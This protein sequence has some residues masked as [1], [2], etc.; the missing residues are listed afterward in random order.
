MSAMDPFPAAPRDHQGALAD[1]LTEK[2]IEILRLLT[3][4]HTVKSIAVRHGGSVSC[5]NRDG[6]GACF[7]LT[8][9]LT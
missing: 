4:G 2:E 5:E 1:K 9:P 6:G 7:V 3:A 8:L